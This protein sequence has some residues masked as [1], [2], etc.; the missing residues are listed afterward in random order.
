MILKD[1]SAQVMSRTNTLKKEQLPHFKDLHCRIE[2]LRLE[3]EG[4][5]FEYST[6][7]AITMTAAYDAAKLVMRC[8]S[9]DLI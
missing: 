7:L 6:S 9:K 8:K 2:T 5:L 3:G 4:E 1:Q